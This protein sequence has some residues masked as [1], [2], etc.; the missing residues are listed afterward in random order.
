VEALAS[1]LIA[2]IE[3]G[4]R[5]IDQAATVRTRH[6]WPGDEVLAFYSSLAEN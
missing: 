3:S 5:P 4:A 1:A 2:T 6:P